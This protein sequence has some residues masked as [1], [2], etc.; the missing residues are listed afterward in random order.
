MAKPVVKRYEGRPPWGRLGP[1]TIV[2]W[3]SATEQADKI[4][5][6]KGKCRSCGRKTWDSDHGDDPRGIL[7]DYCAAPLIAAEHDMI[8]PD[9][10]MCFECGNE[11]DRYLPVEEYALTK[12]W[13]KPAE[14]E[15]PGW[16]ER[17]P[18]VTVDVSAAILIPG[19]YTVKRFYE[20][21]RGPD[22]VARHLSKEEAREMCNGP[23]GSSET[24]TGSD[25]RERTRKRG[26]WF[27]G[28]ELEW[29]QA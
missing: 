24:A 23:E 10:P 6:Y 29:S 27:L 28:F 13:R 7:G 9:V 8:G 15:T 11:A 26:R 12:K 3:H 19:K 2:V 25:A 18:L 1:T 5:R 20:G 22:I 16:P 4:Y 14:G 17:P 21:D